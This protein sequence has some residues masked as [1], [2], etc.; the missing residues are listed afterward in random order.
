MCLAYTPGPTRD[1]RDRTVSL[2]QIRFVA[3]ADS[4][5]EHSLPLN[6]PVAA[7]DSFP[8]P[9]CNHESLHFGLDAAYCPSCRESF[10]PHSKEYKSVIALPPEQSLP[11]KC[12]GVRHTS[13]GWIEK[14]MVRRRWE[15]HRYCWSDRG[16]K[17]IRVH[18]PRDSGKLLA[19]RK[20]IEAGHK[21]EEIVRLLKAIAKT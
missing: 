13:S 1:G 15:H 21:P 4:P 19:V 7:A 8:K 5:P 14:Y 11:Q 9:K 2:S 6:S 17:V 12:S 10:A 18:I 20:A 16:G 3:A